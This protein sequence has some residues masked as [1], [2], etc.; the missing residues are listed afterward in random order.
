MELFGLPGSRN[1]HTRGFTFAKALEML[2][3]QVSIP[4]DKLDALNKSSNASWQ[5][6][7]PEKGGG[8][9]GSLEGESSRRAA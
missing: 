5:R 7:K 6:T 8:V 3:G 2:V 9:I 4:F 1:V